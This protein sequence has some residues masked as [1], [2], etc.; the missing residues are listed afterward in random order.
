MSALRAV[1]AL[2]E[3]G[4]LHLHVAF[5][6]AVQTP[7]DSFASSGPPAPAASLFADF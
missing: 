7:L 1:E 4:A 3:R 2:G 5:S 6:V